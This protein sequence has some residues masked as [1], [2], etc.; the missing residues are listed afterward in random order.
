MRTLVD[1]PDDDVQWLDAAARAQGKSRAAIVRD[2]IAAFRHREEKQGMERYFGLWERHGST[3]DGL[4]YER[5]LRSEWPSL[6]EL[7]RKPDAA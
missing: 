7:D 6:E 1:L 5:A 2:A 4:A 3:T